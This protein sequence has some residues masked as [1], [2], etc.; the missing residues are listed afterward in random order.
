MNKEKKVSA[1]QLVYNE[2]KCTL[3]GIGKVDDHFVGIPIPHNWYPAYQDVRN[4]IYEDAKLKHDSMTDIQISEATL[5]RY[6]ISQHHGFVSN[7][8][9]NEQSVRFTYA[10]PIICMLCRAFGYKLE[11]EDMIEK[12]KDKLS[13]TSKESKAD[14]VCYILTQDDDKSQVIAKDADKVPVV[15]NVSQH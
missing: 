1:S 15:I 13:D 14:Y 5:C 11:L 3:E 12:S 8:I 2:H 10:D 7:K 4:N 6:E 9:K